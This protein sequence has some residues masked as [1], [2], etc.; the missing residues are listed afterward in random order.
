VNQYPYP[1][2]DLDNLT[3]EELIQH[4][5]ELVAEVDRTLERLGA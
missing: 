2:E 3:D 1:T 5:R 4:C